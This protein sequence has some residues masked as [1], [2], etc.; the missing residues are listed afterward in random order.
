[1]PLTNECQC[2]NCQYTRQ[3]GGYKP[4][5]QFEHPPKDSMAEALK[6]FHDA[7]INFVNEVKKVFK[8]K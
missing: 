5:R 2:D 7:W 4:C 3:F 1:M 6:E 8:I